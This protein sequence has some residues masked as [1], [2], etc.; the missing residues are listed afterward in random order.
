[1]LILI[2]LN[3]EV[4]SRNW[5]CVD[6]VSKK[7]NKVTHT[8]RISKDQKSEKL[9]IKLISVLLIKTRTKQPNKGREI[10]VDNSIKKLTGILIFFVFFFDRVHNFDRVY[11]GK[12]FKHVYLFKTFNHVK[13]GRTVNCGLLEPTITIQRIR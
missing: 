4:V 11:N 1:M 5:K 8:L 10:I 9:R 6:E 3:Q 2:E 7:N 12:A 13:I